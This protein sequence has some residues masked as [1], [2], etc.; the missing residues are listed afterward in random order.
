MAPSETPARC[1]TSLV[2]VFSGPI[3]VIDEV[4]AYRIL[5][6]VSADVLDMAPF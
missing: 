4:A 3:W 1:A 6:R 5:C 2:V